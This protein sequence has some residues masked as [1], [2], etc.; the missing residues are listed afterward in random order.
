MSRDPHGNI[1]LSPKALAGLILALVVAS[2]TGGAL[3]TTGFHS[4]AQPVQSYNTR[5]VERLESRLE[6][7]DQRLQGVQERLQRVETQLDFLIASQSP[8]T[9]KRR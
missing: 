7:M 5:D 9:P 1:T 8:S 2:G 4:A 3:S 6:Q